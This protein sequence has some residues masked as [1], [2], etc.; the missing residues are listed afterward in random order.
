[1]RNG[2]P[3]SE[4]VKGL[5]ERYPKGTRV[6]LISMDDAYTTLQ[7]G[8]KGIVTGVDDIGT[9][10]VKW[11]KGSSL[12]VAYGADSIKRIDNER[13][14][15]TGADFWRDS[16]TRYGLEEAAGTC[17]R[18]LDL[19][20]SMEN[21]REEKQFCRELFVEMMEGDT[22]ITDPT[23][24]VYPYSFQK[25]D[26][27]GEVVFYDENIERNNAC[28]EAIEAA[29]RASCYRVN[30]YN[31]EIAAMKVIHE[32]GFERVKM[33]LAHHIQRHDYDGRYSSENKKWATGVEIPEKAFERV[34][35]NSHA[36]LVDD[37]ARYAREMYSEL[38]AERF[39]VPG[40]EESGQVVQ[41]YEI[42][43][44]IR[45]NNQR[46]FAI[47]YNPNAAAQ[48]VCWQFTAENGHRD[49]YWGHYAATEKAATDDYI[50]RVIVHMKDEQAIEIPN[51]LAAEEMS[52]EQNYNMIDGQRNNMDVENGNVA[53]G[54]LHEIIE[55]KPSVVEKIREARKAPPAPYKKKDTH[56]KGGTEREL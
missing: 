39:A 24:I 16:T 26:E 19:R 2:F 1:M 20:L 6:E 56:E 9:I 13:H 34:N 41:G 55:E 40:H 53:D 51:P 50:A 23:K 5:R 49:F 15:E 42:Q 4:I 8:D 32:Y 27:R 54:Q 29:I 30:F 21:S 47:G 37:F 44:S 12:G 52:A 36:I 38:K 7:P 48:Y 18:Y 33:T 45:F 10:F 3:S 17:G 14:H 46:G 43:R 31:L 11:D 35:I 25:A 28:V 22:L